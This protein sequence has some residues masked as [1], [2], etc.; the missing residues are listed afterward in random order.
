MKPARSASFLGAV[1]PLELP[2]GEGFSCR[3]DISCYQDDLFRQ[4]GVAE[5]A[6]IVAAGA[7]RRAEYLAGR[8]LCRELLRRHGLPVQVGTGRQREP[9]WPRGWIGSISHS[10]C[11]AVAALAPVGA[12]RI[13]G[14]DLQ[15]WLS[16]VQARETENLVAL[17]GELE[18][19][20]GVWSRAS[21]LTLVFSA[22]ESL[23][24]ALYPHVGQYFDF[25]S[26]VVTHM[27][28][29]HGSFV[30]ELRSTLS[31]TLPAGSRYIGRWYGLGDH[32]LT[33]I[34]Q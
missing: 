30:I 34:A 17:P 4:Y 5:S 32:L 21:L 19:L 27:D 26:A 25:D 8:F 18:A 2:C 11:M 24:K 15:P 28:G 7:G 12:D 13:L 29:G 31:S 1:L 6:A 22:K 9:V 20:A 16:P 10:D 33:V 14:L 23:F 3:F